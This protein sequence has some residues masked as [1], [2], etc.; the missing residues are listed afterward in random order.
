[1]AFKLEPKYSTIKDF[2][3]W[4][5]QD[6]ARYGRLDQHLELVD[7]QSNFQE[8]MLRIRLYTDGH[9]YTIDARE[10]P[11]AQGYLGCVARSRKERTGEDWHRGSDL[12]DGPLTKITWHRI[13]GDIV[14]YEMMRVQRHAFSWAPLEAI[15]SAEDPLIFNKKDDEPKGPYGIEQQPSASIPLSIAQGLGKPVTTSGIELPGEPSD[16]TIQTQEPS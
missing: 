14:S 5:Q 1:M 8:K 6:I 15:L 9:V 4:M 10:K 16:S 2:L 12:A 3:A 7:F 11:G 13:L